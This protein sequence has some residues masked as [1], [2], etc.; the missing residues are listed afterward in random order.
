M[1]NN[2]DDDVNVVHLYSAKCT[3]SEA[4]LVNHLYGAPSQGRLLDSQCRLGFEHDTLRLLL[5]PPYAGTQPI[6]PTCTTIMISKMMVIV[7]IAAQV[8][9]QNR[10]TKW[11][12]R[13]AV[14]MATAR[15]DLDRMISQ[16]EEEDEEEDEDDDNNNDDGGNRRTNQRKGRQ[17]H[18]HE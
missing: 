18:H 14:A 7:I 6:R 3:A 11:R 13:H 5:L 12:K 10:R 4:L 8:W 16:N 15:K 17:E 9:F 1:R 2:D